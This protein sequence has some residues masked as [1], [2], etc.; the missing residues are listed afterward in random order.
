M[1]RDRKSAQKQIIFIL[2]LT[3][4]WSLENPLK[5][6]KQMFENKTTE[7]KKVVLNVSALLL[8]LFFFLNLH[9]FV[10]TPE[11]KLAGQ[12]RG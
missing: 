11:V 3:N 10:E 7:K 4:F 1:H 12:G 5:C 6:G 2:K 9:Q 8:C